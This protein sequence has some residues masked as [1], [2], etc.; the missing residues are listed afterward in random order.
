M[1]TRT[2]L[3][4]EQLERLPEPEVGNYELDHGELIYVSPNDLRH[5]RVRDKLYV[6]MREFVEREELGEATAETLFE[7]APGTVRAPDIAFI[8]A[9]QV[10]GINP[11]GVLR[12]VPKLVVEILSPANP[13]IEMAR[14]IQLY[15][16]SGVVAI[17]I[18][19]PS[20]RQAEVHKEGSVR[21]VSGDDAL[22]D[23]QVLP[24]FSIVLSELFD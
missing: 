22:S 17:W 2:L 1:S 20:A 18:L 3:T 12:L 24:G 7:F 5:N 23:A 6:R 16:N 9:V 8:P 15:L 13:A 4:T 19:D 21:A 14:R 11:E 10:R